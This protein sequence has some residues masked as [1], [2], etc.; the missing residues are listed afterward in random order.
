MTI[1]GNCDHRAGIPDEEIH[2]HY[3]ELIRGAEAIL[4]GRITYQLMEFWREIVR[5][6]TGEKA[7]DDFAIAMDNIPKLVFSN[8]LTEVDWESAR[9]A[10]RGIEEELSEL[11]QQSAK[12][13]LV[14]SRSLIIGLM[15]LGLID[16]LQLCIHPVVDGPGLPLFQNLNKRTV[17]KL[18]GT[19]VFGGGAVVH[20][21]QPEKG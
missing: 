11:K 3:E 8:T 17:F 13:I 20:Y 19:K 18:A 15:E 12:D 6:P 1:D 16:E 10:S 14:G 7:M 2:Q 9:L 4:Y 5:K 21:Y